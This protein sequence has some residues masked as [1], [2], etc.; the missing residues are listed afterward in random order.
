MKHFIFARMAAGIV[1]ATFLASGA[2]AAG[3]L[4]HVSKVIPKEL[5]LFDPQ[6]QEPVKSVLRVK[7]EGKHIAIEGTVGDGAGYVIQIPGEG[8]FLIYAED[9]ETNLDEEFQENCRTKVTSASAAASGTGR[10]FG[11]GCTK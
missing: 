8:K 1:A 10:G 4:T 7:L 6:T 11:A 9:V 3:K 2:V 5:N